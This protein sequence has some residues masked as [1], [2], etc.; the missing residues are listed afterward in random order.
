VT[1]SARWL[2]HRPPLHPQ[3][4]HAEWTLTSPEEKDLEINKDAGFVM[5]LSHGVQL[6][7][8][9]HAYILHLGPRNGEWYE[10]MVPNE[11]GADWSWSSYLY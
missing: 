3:D 2:N 11:R 6:Q 8:E 7:R 4:N 5:Y 9:V 10:V 1:R